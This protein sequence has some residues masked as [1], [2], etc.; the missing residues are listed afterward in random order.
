MRFSESRFDDLIVEKAQKNSKKQQ[1]QQE[2]S[3]SVG[4]NTGTL[5]K[6]IENALNDYIAEFP[7]ERVCNLALDTRKKPTTESQDRIN[8]SDMAFPK[9]GKKI[10]SLSARELKTELAKRNQPTD[11][12]RRGKC[13]Q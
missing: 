13:C 5:S 3:K 11:G 12:N 9:L 7:G 1:S 2:S 4:D 10:D 8:H 6:L